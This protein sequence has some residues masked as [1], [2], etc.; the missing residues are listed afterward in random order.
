[1]SSEMLMLNTALSFKVQ[2]LRL[3]STSVVL[4]H[5]FSYKNTKFMVLELFNYFV[6][7]KP[8]TLLSFCDPFCY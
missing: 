2:N 7:L 3:S 5:K 1:M 8:S 4:Y 6:D